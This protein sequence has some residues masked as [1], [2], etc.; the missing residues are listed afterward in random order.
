MDSYIQL[1]LIAKVFF[2]GFLSMIIGFDRERREKSAGLRTHMLAGMGACLFTAVS[3]EVFP[4]PDASRIPSEVVSG[5]GFLGAGVVFYRKGDDQVHELT[6]AATIWMTAA[7]GL[8][9]GL[10]AW[11]VAIAATLFAWFVLVVVRHFEVKHLNTKEEPD[12]N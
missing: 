3:L 7:V 10:D 4:L 6:T 11:L 2:A 9:V 1:I 5:I 8:A 12:T